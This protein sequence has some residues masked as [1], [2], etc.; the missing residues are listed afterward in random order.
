MT[1]SGHFLY[2]Q[3]SSILKEILSVLMATVLA[4]LD[5]MHY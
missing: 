3:C 2:R 5:E 4:I 1:K